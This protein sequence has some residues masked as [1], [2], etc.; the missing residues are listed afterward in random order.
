MP[1]R[2]GRCEA[3]AAIAHDDRGHA[4]PARGRHFGIPGRLAVIM[5]VD[6]DKARRD[7]PAGRVDFLATLVFDL[8]DGRD[9]AL[10]DCDIAPERRAAR[11]IDDGSAP[12]H[13][14]MHFDS[15]AFRFE[16]EP[17]TD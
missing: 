6:V 14:I 4:M 3:D 7:D 10:V 2:S 5:G 1:V 11:S 12:D 8:A 16:T 13:Q 15:P 9:Q 17:I